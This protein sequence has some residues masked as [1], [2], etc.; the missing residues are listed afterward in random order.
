MDDTAPAEPGSTQPRSRSL[1]PFTASQAGAVIRGLLLAALLVAGAVGLVTDDPARADFQTLLHDVRAGDVR[2]VEIFNETQNAPIVRWRTS[3]WHWWS[4]TVGTDQ[5]PNASGED[6]VDVRATIEREARATG[7]EVD[8]ES[9]SRSKLWTANLPWPLLSSV[10]GGAWLVAL[11]L[12]FFNDRTRYANRWAWL[13][14]FTFGGAGALLYLWL[15]PRPLWRPRQLQSAPLRDPRRKVHGV[16]GF[17]YAIGLGILVSLLA[18]AARW[19]L[20]ADS[21][22]HSGQMITPILFP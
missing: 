15:E 2:T 10:A 11:L 18:F 21:R 14:L 16:V 17:V 6:R 1:L 22:F 5:A 20:G 9:R 3:W 19:A 8:V 7:H 13:W 4:T 12:M